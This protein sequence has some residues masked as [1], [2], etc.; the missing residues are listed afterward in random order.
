M[1]EISY[2]TGLISLAVFPVLLTLLGGILL[3][4][5][6]EVDNGDSL[7]DSQQDDQKVYTGLLVLTMTFLILT[8]CGL[9]ASFFLLNR[10]ALLAD[11]D[12][13]RTKRESYDALRSYFKNPNDQN[14]DKS[15]A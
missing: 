9:L 4:V 1:P 8:Q 10:K 15:I 11:L 12:F 7:P 3:I 2:Y 14:D 5:Y 6:Y 13:W